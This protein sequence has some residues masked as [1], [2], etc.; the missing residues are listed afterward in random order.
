[1]SEALPESNA[2]VGVQKVEE[3]PSNHELTANAPEK[4]E[5]TK[6]STCDTCP[7]KTNTDSTKFIPTLCLPSQKIQDK[8]IWVLSP[9][10]TPVSSAHATS[11]IEAT[12]AD[13]LSGP[14][15]TRDIKLK[16]EADSSLNTCDVTQLVLSGFVT[17]VAAAENK[18]KKPHA[19]E[20]VSQAMPQSSEKHAGTLSFCYV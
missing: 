20:Y 11:S 3:I 12:G 17:Q 14:V 13:A 6:S 10:C 4:N 7:V 2:V 9:N 15:D 18:E 1:M 8:Q 5:L 19:V 16:R